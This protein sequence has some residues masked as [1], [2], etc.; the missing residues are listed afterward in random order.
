MKILFVGRNCKVGG[1]C[2][3]RYRS[4]LGLIERGHD[5]FLA[6][7]GGPMAGRFGAAGVKHYKVLPT[8]FNRLQL[9]SI[10]RKEK[11]ELVHACNPTAGDDVVFARRLL[12]HKPKFVMS[13]HGNLPDYVKGNRCLREASQLMTFDQSALDRLRRFDFL[14][15]R[16][17]HLIRR[18]VERRE[19]PH[20]SESNK[21]VVT[22]S[23]LSKSKG[24]VA[25]A[26]IEAVVH[27]QRD[28]PGLSLTIVGNGTMLRTIR[29][30]AESVN[31]Q[32]GFPAITVTGMLVDPF[33]VMAAASCVVGTSYVAL[34]ALFHGIPVVAAG[35]E[36][37][38]LVTLDGLEEAI[39]CN[40][41]DGFPGIQ[42]KVTKEMLAEGFRQVFEKTAT[43]E[44]REEYVRIR[45]YLEEHHSVSR[46]AEALERIYL[47]A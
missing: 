10:M 39:A 45:E 42:E 32:L 25:V 4:A 9:A 7:Q 27:L 37:Y 35:Y 26:A 43:P 14:K 23:R 2:T 11:I 6:A 36:G 46:T 28:Y 18:P 22:V 33:P 47:A 19:L 3:F 1:G 30:Q 41:G 12:K 29:S 24:P 15:D 38:G 13:I 40:F 21:S 44:G 34:E 17:I 20:R 31:K 5:V 16:P 8:P